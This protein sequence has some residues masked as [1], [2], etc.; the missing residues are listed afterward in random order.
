MAGF[1]PLYDWVMAAPDLSNKE[2]Q[3]VCRVLRWGEGGC[4]ESN[5]TLGRQLKMDPRTVRRLVKELVKKEW[6]AV[7]YPRRQQRLIFVDPRRLT[8]GPLF[9]RIGAAT[10][11]R[12]VAEKMKI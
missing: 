1:T 12:I 3:I 7:L 4:F 10:M 8:A 5:A 9:E 2:A 6:L 11:K